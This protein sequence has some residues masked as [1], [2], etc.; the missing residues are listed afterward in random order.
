MANIFL[1]RLSSLTQ[2]NEFWPTSSQ[3]LNR[4]GLQESLECLRS[5][6][7]SFESWC[8]NSFPDFYRDGLTTAPWLECRHA[9]SHSIVV[10]HFCGQELLVC[11]SES[12]PQPRN[13]HSSASR[14]PPFMGS[15]YQF[16]SP[17]KISLPRSR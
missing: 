8:F 1:K 4:H 2:K 6:F 3:P 9:F 13:H 12:S 7:S 15:R 16:S 17:V 5:R 10:Q 11:G 14:R